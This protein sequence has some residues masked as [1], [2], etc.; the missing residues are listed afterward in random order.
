MHWLMLAKSG[1]GV[2]TTAD[3]ILV[4][5]SDAIPYRFGKIAE[6]VCHLCSI[7]Q[8]EKIDQLHF[9]MNGMKR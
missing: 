8:E 3:K 4:G 1:I 2:L 6:N 7:L 9:V 5:I